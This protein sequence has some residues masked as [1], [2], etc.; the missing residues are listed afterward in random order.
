MSTSR[1]VILRLMPVLDFGGVESRIITQ[2]GLMDRARFDFR[3]CT[4]WKRGAAAKALEAQGVP[5]DELGTDPAPTNPRAI[6]RLAEYTFSRRID[7][8]HAS[9]L[10]ANLQAAALRRIPGAPAVAIEEVGMPVRSLKARLSFGAIYRLA[11]VVI[12]VSS[13]ACEAVRTQHWLPERKVRLIYNSINP[14]FFEPLSA[15]PQPARPRLL[16]VGRLVPVKNHETVLRALAALPAAE[17]PELHIAGEGP[18]RASLETLI[19]ELGLSRHARL[20]GFQENVRALLDEY[21]GYV[22]SSFSEGTSISL[23]EAMA[24]GRPVV[25][26]V[27]DGIDEAMVGYPPGWQVPATDVPAWAEALHR[28]TAMAPEE[29]AALGRTA[30]ALVERRMSPATW[31]QQLHALYDELATSSRERRSRPLGRLSRAVTSTF[32]GRE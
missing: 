24:R 4:F 6:A 14:R 15:R 7:V 16:V 22:M 9:I 28:L 19:G 3:V 17:R 25:T 20:L 32:M 2:S 23:A 29:R 30:R 18:L 13:K 27:A 10:E 21:D 12:G 1:P 5:V 31:S 11:D 8:I 26:S